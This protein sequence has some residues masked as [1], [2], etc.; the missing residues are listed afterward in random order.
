MKSLNINETLVEFIKKHH[1]LTLATCVDSVP[2]CSNMFYTL[3]E[4]EFWLVFTSDKKTRHIA[5][6]SQN[7]IVA[8]SIVLETETI[9]KI[10][11]LQFCGKMM[12]VE[13]K[14]KAK[15]ITAYLKRFP[16]VI[17]SMSPI[18]IIEITYAK[19]TDNKLGFGKK[20]IWERDIS[21]P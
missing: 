4:E 19:L 3:M 14:L 17:L 12:E 2:Y 18:W 1:V 5:E 9:G 6:V 7:N 15:A 20:I 13:H 8:G 11:G 21:T 16:Y 10:Q